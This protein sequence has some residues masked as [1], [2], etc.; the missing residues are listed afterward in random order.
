MLVSLL[1]TIAL[2]APSPWLAVAFA[3]T[4]GLATA[5]AGYGTIRLANAGRAEARVRN[6]LRHVDSRQAGRPSLAIRFSELSERVSGSLMRLFVRNTDADARAEKLKRKL[7]AAGIYAVDAPKVFLAARFVLLGIG[8]GI[9]L[10]ASFVIGEDP[11][12]VT[13]IGAGIGYMLPAFWLSR[14]T[15]A[16]QSA[17]STGLPDALDLLVVCV[18]AGLTIDAGMQR[19]GRELTLAHPAVARE[20]TIC[21]ME[22]RIGVPRAQALR[23]LGERSGLPQFKGM[24][25]MLVQA[26]RFGTS[27]A[28][29][30]RVQADGLREKRRT[31]VEEAA[32]KASVK[33]TFPLVLFIFPASFIVMAGPVVLKMMNSEMF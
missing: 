2:S 31:Q 28:N 29:A 10:L 32:A 14:K 9:G 20:L 27:I 30:L 19:V 11:F 13:P 33:L 12:L 8:A 25:A 6:R 3:A 21:H 4:L 1:L 18:E 22:T 23:N 7:I 26:E 5:A 17:I 16:N 15:K 24:C